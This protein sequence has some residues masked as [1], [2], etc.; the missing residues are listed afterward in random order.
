MA[1]KFGAASYMGAPKLSIPTSCL[2]LLIGTF[3]TPVLFNNLYSR[4]LCFSQGPAEVFRD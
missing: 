2:V 3:I 1:L 4:M